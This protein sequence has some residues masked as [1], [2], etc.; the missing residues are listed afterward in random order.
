MGDQMALFNQ[1]DSE[2]CTKATDVAR[3][4]QAVSSLGSESR[5]AKLREL[6][7]DLKEADQIVKRME[8]EARSFSADR[9]RV[10]LSKVREY[11]ADLAKLRESAQAAA[12]S[13]PGGAA[14]RAELG[15]ADD[16]SQTSAGQRERLLQTTE[17]LGRTGERITQGRQQLLE[18][19]EL[20]VSILQDLHRQR[21][22][23]SHARDTLHG[24][25][26]NIAK[27]RRVLSN[28]SRR[29]TTN[30]L[31]AGAIILLLLAAIV[32]VVYYKFIK[33]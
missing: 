21:Q 20:G 29:I 17:K 25:D 33:K 14:A 8:M 5:R 24:A 2:Y 32:L 28:M 30:K 27:A 19:E 4:V 23:I 22:T 18:T 15:L 12:A 31:I 26:D 10:L 3:K 7:S 1:Y 13:E 16:Y 11:K 9:S 6:E